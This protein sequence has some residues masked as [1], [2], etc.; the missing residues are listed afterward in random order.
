MAC[1]VTDLLLL[2]ST[3][4]RPCSWRWQGCCEPPL[5]W[6]RNSWHRWQTFSRSQ[7]QPRPVYYYN[8]SI[9]VLLLLLSMSM[10]V[11]T[12]FV[13]NTIELFDRLEEDCNQVSTS[14]AILKMALR[15]ECCPQ[16]LHI[17]T[18][19]TKLNTE[20]GRRQAMKN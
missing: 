8:N 9:T 1:E 20:N 5:R 19:K 15:Q 11:I 10:H 12:V 17:A 13:F 7:T 14:M 4:P 18:T 6:T 3:C 2:C 16:L